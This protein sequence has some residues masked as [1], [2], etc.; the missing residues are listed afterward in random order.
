MNPEYSQY[1]LQLDIQWE[2]LSGHSNTTW[3]CSTC[4][5]FGIRPNPHANNF[6]VVIK[7]WE[8]EI[9]IHNRII[10]KSSYGNHLI[11]TD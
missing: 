5:D 1:D 4:G 3:G 2:G 9:T 10:I 11:M 8:D 6:S 7:N